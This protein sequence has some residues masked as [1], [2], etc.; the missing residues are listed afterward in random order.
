MEDPFWNKLFKLLLDKFGVCHNVATP[1]Y[2]QTSGQVDVSSRDIKQ[3]FAMIVNA[4]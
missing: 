1:N 2:P 3:I 4:N